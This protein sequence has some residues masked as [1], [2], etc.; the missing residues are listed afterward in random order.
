MLRLRDIMTWD[1]F[2]VTSETPVELAADKM[3]TA[4]GIARWSP[5]RTPSSESSRRR[6]SRTPLPIIG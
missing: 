2:A 4:R 3:R 5:I 1:V 6:T